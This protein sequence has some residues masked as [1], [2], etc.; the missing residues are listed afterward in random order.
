MDPTLLL[1]LDDLAEKSGRYRTE[2]Y[3]W[4]LRLLQTTC[5]TLQREG[6]VTGQ[7]L[8]KVQRDLAAREFGPLA[9]ETLSYWGLEES[10]D[11]GRVVFDLVEAGHLGKTEDDSLR[12]FED[13]YDFGEAF[14]LSQPW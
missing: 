1:A 12:D 5:E 4:V 3:V 8:L 7:E 10:L 2:A 9:R 11:I 13:G 14:P 6:H